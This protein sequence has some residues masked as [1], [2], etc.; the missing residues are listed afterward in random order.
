MPKTEFGNKLMENVSQ[1]KE[2]CDELDRMGR[3][4]LALRI[5]VP[6]KT[7]LELVTNSSYENVEK[8]LNMMLE[9]S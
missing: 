9:N 4:D 5:M 2:V 1:I 8:V 6:V 7:M 3:P